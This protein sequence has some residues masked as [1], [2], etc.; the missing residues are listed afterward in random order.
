MNKPVIMIV[1]DD[2]QVL[3]A[4]RRDLRAHYRENYA[5]LSANSGEE[6]LTTTRELKSRGDAL[7]IVVALLD[8]EWV[9]ASE[10][11]RR[12]PRSRFCESPIGQ[13]SGA[14]DGSRGPC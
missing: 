7:A 3:A 1:D 14:G 5:V 9:R 4:V 11:S 6:A 8:P 13:N 10:L 2:P 12:E